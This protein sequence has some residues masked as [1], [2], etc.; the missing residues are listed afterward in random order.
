VKVRSGLAAKST[1]TMTSGTKR[2]DFRLP[3]VHKL[4]LS[5]REVIL[6]LS[7]DFIFMLEHSI[8]SSDHLNLQPSLQYGIPK[9]KTKYKSFGERFEL[10]RLFNFKN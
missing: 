10:V 8:S 4:C 1:G 7:F 9:L 6:C 3:K 2:R 5:I